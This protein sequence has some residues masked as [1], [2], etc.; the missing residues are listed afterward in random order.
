MCFELLK[1]YDVVLNPR[2]VALFQEVDVNSLRTISALNSPEKVSGLEQAIRESV[3][4][5]LR[6]QNQEEKIKLL[7]VKFV[8][9]PAQFKFSL[10][11]KLSISEASDMA[12]RI[13]EE[14]ESQYS[15][16][17]PSGK[18]QIRQNALISK[19]PRIDSGAATGVVL[20][21]ASVT[22]AA[23]GITV[24]SSAQSSSE[25][26]SPNQITHIERRKGKTLNEYVRNWFK[27]T[28]LLIDQK[29]AFLPEDF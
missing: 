12:E 13:L 2:L 10:G 21:S 22:P 11:E 24:S 19:R 28:R 6:F 17:R 1:K 26:S 18:R 5:P 23:V 27:H 4:G 15:F 20:P 8:G 7:G 25:S 9:D 16:Q 3:S 14:Y 29:I